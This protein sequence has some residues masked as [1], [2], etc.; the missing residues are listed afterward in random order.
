MDL[1]TAMAAQLRRLTEEELTEEK[2]SEESRLINL[3]QAFSYMINAFL[4][5]LKSKE[6]ISQ[7]SS[8]PKTFATLG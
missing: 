6:D 4:E 7:P 2:P 5:S 8:T 1:K 3:L